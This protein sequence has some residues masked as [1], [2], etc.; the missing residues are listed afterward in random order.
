MNLPQKRWLDI[1]ILV[2]SPSEDSQSNGH[3]SSWLTALL[4]S[5]SFMSDTALPMQ[6]SWVLVKDL[7]LEGNKSCGA[8][9]QN[10]HWHISNT[11]RLHSPRA[12]SSCVSLSLFTLPIMTNPTEF[13]QDK[14][15]K[16]GR[17]TE[18]QRSTVPFSYKY[19]LTSLLLHHLQQSSPFLSSHCSPKTH[20]LS[21][22]E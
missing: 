12:A 4:N 20:F 2:V 18:T 19:F 3:Q 6:G 14:P 8:S 13:C 22:F 1:L 17:S 15:L 16:L 7:K 9:P 10:E 5:R 21:S 11:S